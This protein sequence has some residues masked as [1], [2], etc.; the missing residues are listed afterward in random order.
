MQ[1][2][3]RKSKLGSA[4]LHFLPQKAGPLTHVLGLFGSVPESSCGGGFT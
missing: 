3:G 1:R 4:E 2:R